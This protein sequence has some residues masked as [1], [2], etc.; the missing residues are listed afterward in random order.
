MRRQIVKNARN[1]LMFT[2][3]SISNIKRFEILN[4]HEKFKFLQ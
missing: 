2:L 3:L 1:K 4:F